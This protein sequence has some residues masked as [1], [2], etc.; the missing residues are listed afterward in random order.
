MKK[1]TLSELKQ[2]NNVKEVKEERNVELKGGFIHVYA[3]S[4]VDMPSSILSDG[5]GFVPPPGI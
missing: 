3:Y 4:S 2:L 5:L 1:A